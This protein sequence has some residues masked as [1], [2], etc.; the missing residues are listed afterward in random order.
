[1]SRTV[2]ITPVRNEA[3]IRALERDLKAEFAK[4]CPDMVEVRRLQQ[5]LA[6]EKSR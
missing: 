5:K 3:L 2:D 4:P 6:I 1:M